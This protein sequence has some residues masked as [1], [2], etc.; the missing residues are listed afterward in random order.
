MTEGYAAVITLVL[1]V[2][3]GIRYICSTHTINP[4]IQTLISTMMGVYHSN[5]PVDAISQPLQQYYQLQHFLDNY[6]WIC[7]TIQGQQ[8]LPTSVSLCSLHSQPS[9]HA[10]DRWHPPPTVW[11]VWRPIQRLVHYQTEADATADATGV[12]AATAV[13]QYPTTTLATATASLQ[14]FTVHTTQHNT[15]QLPQPCNWFVIDDATHLAESLFAV[16]SIRFDLIQS[17][18][19]AVPLKWKTR[20]CMPCR[21]H[22]VQLRQMPIKEETNNLH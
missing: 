13:P 18:S 2:V 19:C 22:P 9:W 15:T 11:L 21:L 14:P 1:L 5:V 6:K 17:P 7:T 16:N 12:E 10:T 8:S 20:W 4:S 3:S